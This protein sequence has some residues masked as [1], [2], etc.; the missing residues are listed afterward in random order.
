MT[1][2]TPALKAVTKTSTAMRKAEEKFLAAKAARNTA[3]LE[4][5]EAGATYPVLA[6]ASGLTRDRISQVLT[7]T[8]RQH[9]A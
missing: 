6:E 7:A 8:R 9:T 3:I 4:A 5:Q 1:D 2:P